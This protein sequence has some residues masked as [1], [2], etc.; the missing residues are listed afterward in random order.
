MAGYCMSGHVYFR[1]PKAS[2]NTAHEYNK[3]SSHYYSTFT[4]AIISVE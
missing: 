3:I 1:E 2:E 4:G